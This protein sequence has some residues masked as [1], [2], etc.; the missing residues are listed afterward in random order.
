M[1]IDMHCHV[2]EGSVDSKVSLEEYITLLKEKGFDGMLITDHNTY[3]GYRYWKEHIK[4]KKHTDF[5]VLKGIEYDTSDAGHII[6]IMPGAVQGTNQV[7]LTLAIRFALYLVQLRIAKVKRNL[8]CSL[9]STWHDYNN[10]SRI[11]CI[12]FNSFQDNKICMFF[13]FDMFLPV[14]VPL[15][16]VVIRDQ[17]PVKTFLFQQGNI[18]FQTYLTIHRTFFYVTMHIN[19][20][21]PAS[22]SYYLLLLYP[23]FCKV[24]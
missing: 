22:L 14:S 19:L 6:V 1:K 5:V 17:H 10:M 9:N 13:P 18:F 2:K 7:T 4:G 24:Q 23:F 15:V 12:I 20:H 16:C 3:K 11:T 21:K 8:V